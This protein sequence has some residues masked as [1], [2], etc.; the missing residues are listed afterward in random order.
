MAQLGNLVERKFQFRQLNL[1][2]LL[3]YVF[4]FFLIAEIN[5]SCVN[6]GCIPK[7]LMHQGGLL[8]ESLHDAPFYGWKPTNVLPSTQQ[9]AGDTS[10]SHKEDEG[11]TVKYVHDW[12]T[13]RNNVSLH[14]R[15]SNFSYTADLRKN[16][17]DYFNS[18]GSFID[19]HTIQLN[20]SIGDKTTLTAEN[21]VIATGGRPTYLDIP[22]KEFAI[23]SDDL[24]SL[25]KPPGKTLCIGAGYIS[26]ECAGFLSEFGYETS[27][28]IRSRPLRSF[29]IECVSKIVNRMEK[30]TKFLYGTPNKFE[31][32]QDGRILVEWTSTQSKEVLTE[33]YD[34]VLMAVGRTPVTNTLGLDKI[35]VKIDEKSKK[36]IGNDMEQSSVKNI[37]AIGDVVDRGL[38]LTP[39]AIKAGKLL[40]ERLFGGGTEKMDYHLVPTTVFTPI[41]YGFIGMSEE[42]AIKKYGSVVVYKKNCKYYYLDT[43]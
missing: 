29:D 23:T 9:Q 20:P 19:E 6:V 36:V 2:F 15:S 26:L 25:K 24:F 43:R 8:A 34:T 40:A 12:N 21:F 10:S 32:T 27:L 37:Y 13:L 16:K 7:K 22:G 17:I 33:V 35:N 3:V 18:L 38:E 5:Y 1:S 31:K 28:M 39:V 14:I 11:G 41:E 4:F 30:K 42:E